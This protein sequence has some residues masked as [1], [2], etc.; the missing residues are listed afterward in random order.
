MINGQENSFLLALSSSL[1]NHGC[2]VSSNALLFGS[3]TFFVFFSTY[4]LNNATLDGKWSA[5]NFLFGFDF[6]N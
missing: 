3:A 1:T 5:N 2:S 4:L 6:P